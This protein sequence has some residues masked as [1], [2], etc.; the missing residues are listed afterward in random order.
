MPDSLKGVSRDNLASGVRKLQGYLTK[1][2]D[3]EIGDL[4]AEALM[5]FV[6][7]QVYPIVYNAAIEDARALAAS[8]MQTLDEELFGLER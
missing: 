7:T 3:L 4:E 6:A 1:E 2:F 8:R 5:Q